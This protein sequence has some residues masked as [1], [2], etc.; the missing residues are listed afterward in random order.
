MPTVSAVLPEQAD[1]SA[2]RRRPVAAAWARL[3][4]R[5]RLVAGFAAAIL[6]VLTGAGAFV[7]LR[8]EY[9][10]DLRIN[11]DLSGQA[12]QV[13]AGLAKPGGTLDAGAARSYF[14]VLDS[15]GRVLAHGPGVADTSLLRPQELAAAL[16][17]PQ[18]A[19]R[20]ALLPI[21]THPLRLYAIPLAP[22]A[23]TAAG[24]P[25][26]VVTAVR[27]DQRDEALRELIGQLALADL[28]TLVIASLVGYRMARAALLPVE[29][30]RAEAARIAAGA[31]GVRL[32]VPDASHDE[33]A[34]LGRTLNDML[35]AL[36]AALERERRFVNDASHELRT[37]LTLLSTELELALRRPRIK[38]EMEQALRA[39]A[40]DTAD[41]IALAETLLTVGVQPMGGHRTTA[42]D[43]GEL[44]ACLVDRYRAAAAPRN[45][46]LLSESAPD[47]TVRGDAARLAPVLTN[48]LDNA[49]RHGAGIVTVTACGDQG[50]VL[51]LVHD[52]GPGMDPLFV[53]HATER[54]ARADASHTSPGTGLGLSLVHSIVRAHRGGLRICSSTVHH[55]VD[56]D[57]NPAC[58]H[59]DTGTTVTVILPATA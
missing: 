28:A 39:A 41:L 56:G 53:P 37:P 8:V 12:D 1:R 51:L 58:R 26:V 35:T 50:A 48:L 44:V 4:L 45:R 18:L 14:Q 19:D 15:T 32:A 16:H 33:V 49:L 42:V 47:L 11:E 5:V 59:R 52:H 57:H 29:R 24:P 40:A 7:Y 3:P 2:P 17:G 30:Y 6:L 55:H 31:T 13:S 46:V 34:R 20:G 9:A 27:R 21:S 54:F 10:L 25:A 43:V 22:G 23:V 36:D 38:E